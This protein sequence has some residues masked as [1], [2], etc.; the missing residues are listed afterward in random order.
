MAARVDA[1]VAWRLEDG[2]AALLNLL[3]ERT[4]AWLTREDAPGGKRHVRLLQEHL[5]GHDLTLA[6]ARS[7]LLAWLNPEDNLPEES[8]I[9]FE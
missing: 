4:L 8:V 7:V 6:E 5:A 2:A 3:D 9:E 1:V